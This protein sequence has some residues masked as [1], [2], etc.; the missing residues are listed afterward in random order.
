[1]HS[2]NHNEV[3]YVVPVHTH[4]RPHTRTRTHNRAI[5]ARHTRIH[6]TWMLHESCARTANRWARYKYGGDTLIVPLLI[7]S[8]ALAL[9][10]RRSVY[11]PPSHWDALRASVCIAIFLAMNVDAAAA[12]LAAIP[13]E[14]LRVRQRPR[15]EPTDRIVFIVLCPCH[16]A[17]S[18]VGGGPLSRSFGLPFVF[19]LAAND[20]AAIGAVQVV[21]DVIR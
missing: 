2:N 1:M 17:L 19:A 13:L 7:G 8:S 10:A 5:C 12:V 16:S 18:V 3:Y 4:T 14:M 21:D 11:V 20:I 6:S 9:A 15:C